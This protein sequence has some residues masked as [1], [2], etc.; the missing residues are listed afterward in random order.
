MTEQ[1]TK[2]DDSGSSMMDDV[3]IKVPQLNL[4]DEIKFRAPL[5][6]LI[7]LA[8]IAGI[9]LVA[10]LFSRVLLSVP[11]EAAI[12]IASVM[13]INI[14]GAFAF[15]ALRPD[16]TRVHRAELA[17]V[18]AY[19]LLIGVVI[20]VIGIGEASTEAPGGESAPTEAP[21]AAGDFQLSADGLAFDTDTIEL[22]AGEQQTIAFDNQDSAEHNLSVY[23]DE[24]A[25]QSQKGALF[26]GDNIAAG[27]STEYQVDPLPA[28]EYYFQCDIHPTMNGDV[29]AEAGASGG[30]G[31]GSGSGGSSK[32]KPAGGGK[33][34]N[35][36]GGAG[37]GKGGNGGGG[38]GA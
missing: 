26:A 7:P 19:P 30:K 8:A 31:A 28:G 22:A 15:A 37:G 13:A 32:P 23:Q 20:A 11:R 1:P 24:E 5:P 34:G 21:A 36:G 6:I 29:V 14:L 17:M 3:R 35:G 9:A 16:L 27:D 4:P 38:E 33:G 12:V 2:D 25:G 18:V 10:F